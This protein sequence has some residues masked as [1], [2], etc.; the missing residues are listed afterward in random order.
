MGCCAYCGDEVKADRKGYLW[1]TD[2]N[3]GQPL[4]CDPSPDRRHALEARP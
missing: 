2:P 1:A 4:W 3:D